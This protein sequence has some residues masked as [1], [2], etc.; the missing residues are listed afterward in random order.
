M[1]V[2]LYG[3]GAIGGFIGTRLALTGDCELSAV[4][5][6]ATLAALRQ[7]GLRLRQGGE[8]FCAAV[9]ASDEPATLGVQDLVLVAVKAPSL[10]EVA[11]R[12]AP[13]IGATTLVLPAMN[14]FTVRGASVCPRK[15]FA[16]AESASEPVMPS[17]R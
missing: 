1:K 7:Q 17:A 12:I 15:I 14:G 4:A 10:P 8:L 13:L 5:R 11:A 9:N 3:V 2:C 6:G 16:A